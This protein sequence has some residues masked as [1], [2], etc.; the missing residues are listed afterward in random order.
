MLSM[1]NYK[2]EEEDNIKIDKKEKRKHWQS[3]Y[4]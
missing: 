4:I 2:K 1:P 3:R